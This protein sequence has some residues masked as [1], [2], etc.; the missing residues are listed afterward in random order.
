[1]NLNSV[2]TELYHDLPYIICERAPPNVHEKVR[3]MVLE[4]VVHITTMIVFI[5]SYVG[6]SND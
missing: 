2:K 3:K 5:D 4:R 6:A 1:M